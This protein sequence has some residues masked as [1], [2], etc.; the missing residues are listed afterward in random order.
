MDPLL[1]R[2]MDL[3]I[4]IQQIHGPA[5]DNVFRA[6]SFMGTEK[7]YLLLLPLLL[8]CVDF[9]LGAR[10]TVF[11]L[12]ASYINADLKDLFQQPRPFDLNPSVG[13]I[14][15]EGYALPSG[16]AQSAVVVWGTI[17]TWMRRAWFW[18]LAIGLALLIGFSRIYLGVH[19]PTDVLAGWIIGILLLCLYL[20]VQPRVENW[21]V[22]SS[23]A[24]QILS[25]LGVPLLLLL[26]HPTERSIAALATLAGAG[27]GL[28]LTNRFVS[29]STDGPW[30]QRVS[31]LLIGGT[32]IFA[33]FLGLKIVFPGKE[34]ALYPVFRFIRYFVIGSWASLGG[35]WLFSLLRLAPAKRKHT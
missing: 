11:F 29:F 12:F 28:A 25:A 26:I 17:A 34:S 5:L 4:A 20:V 23:L 10:L 24:T 14:H 32:I 8:W 6:I 2:G 35:P 21:L 9:G 33:L 15:A 3:I 22:E 19:F 1:Q 30:W 31:R 27:V 16:H 7:F 13:L 18:I